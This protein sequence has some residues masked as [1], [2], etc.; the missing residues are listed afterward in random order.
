VLPLLDQER[1]RSARWLLVYVVLFVVLMSVAA[2]KLDRYMLPALVLL[3]VVAGVGLWRLATH[4]SRAV[5]RLA[6]AAGHRRWLSFGL[7]AACV[8]GQAAQLWMAEPYPIAAYNPLAG[9][10]SRAGRVIM[11]GWGEGLEQVA[12]F[13]NRQ[14]DAQELLV[15]TNYIHVMRPRL[16]ATPIPI[17]LYFDNEHAAALPTPDYVVLYINSVQRRQIPPIARRAI[18]A[19]PPVFVA[20]VNGEEYAWVY[21][22]P[23]SE[24][25][26]RA[27]IPADDTSDQEDN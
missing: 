22:V 4:A 19:G 14:P 7:L 20:D 2:K 27:P 26:I 17:N 24:P 6:P 16:S 11:L 1:P 15:A 23:G 8:V 12:A 18:R 3:D 13:L 5:A 21:A 10:A 25:R 9:G